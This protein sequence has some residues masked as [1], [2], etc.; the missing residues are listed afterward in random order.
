MVYLPD[1]DARS[2]D[3]V[4]RKVRFDARSGAFLGRITYIRRNE[5][6]PNSR[7]D[8]DNMGLMRAEK[9]TGREQ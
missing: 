6:A 2:A 7:N 9:A 3:V 8:G 1:A 4:D 5:G